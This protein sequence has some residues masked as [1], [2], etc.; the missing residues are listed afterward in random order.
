VNNSTDKKVNKYRQ[1]KDVEEINAN[2]DLT[3]IKNSIGF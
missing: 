3:N 1:R 2:G